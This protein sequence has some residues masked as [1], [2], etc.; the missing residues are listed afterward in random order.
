MAT[1]RQRRI[2]YFLNQGFFK[3]EA[4]ELSRTSRG[5]MR[6]P[7]FQRMIRSRRRLYDNSKRYKW[8]EQEYRDYVKKL[9]TDRGFVK[10]DVLGRRRVD[11]WAMLREFEERARRIGEEYES[12]WR[13]RTKR[14][15]EKKREVKRVTRKDMLRSMIRQINRSMGRTT[16]PQRLAELTARKNYLVLQLERMD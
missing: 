3:G 13:K 6:A 9:Y 4:I 7:Y 5:G 15:T 16:N 11:V 14:K 12:P 2:Q 8:T 10:T 1:M